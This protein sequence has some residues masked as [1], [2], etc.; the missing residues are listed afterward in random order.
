MSWEKE[1]TCD[2]PSIL[3]LFHNKFNKFD[4]TGA[5]TLDSFYHMALKLLLN[6]A[7]TENDFAIY[8]QHY[9]KSHYNKCYQNL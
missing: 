5:G 9:Y 7:L 6:R 2:L 1:I 8:M 3:L 4:N